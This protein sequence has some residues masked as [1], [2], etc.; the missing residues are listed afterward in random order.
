MARQGKKQAKR[1]AARIKDWESMKDTVDN[2]NKKGIYNE[3]YYRKPGS[4]K[5]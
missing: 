1:L 4:N 5:K 3:T 2:T